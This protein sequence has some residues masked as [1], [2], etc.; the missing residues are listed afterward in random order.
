[1]AVPWGSEIQPRPREWICAI[2]WQSAHA[3]AMDGDTLVR[4]EPAQRGAGYL[5]SQSRWL[6][7]DPASRG[8]LASPWF[9]L[10]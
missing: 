7:E 9:D 4:F 3:A 1:M 6:D 5:S 2:G 10:T 8:L